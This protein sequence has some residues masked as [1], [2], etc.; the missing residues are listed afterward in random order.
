M[1][2]TQLQDRSLLRDKAYVDGRW[3]EADNG[4]SFSV[5]NPPRR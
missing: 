2:N 5:K 1:A 4:R 3:I